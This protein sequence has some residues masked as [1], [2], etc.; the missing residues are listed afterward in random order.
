MEGA[1]TTVS[2]IVLRPI[3]PAEVLILLAVLGAAAV[4]LA[5]ARGLKGAWL[6]LLSLAALLLALANP[7]LVREDRASLSDVV[8]R[9]RS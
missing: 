1:L 4:L 8:M 5:L 7:A 6:R 9:Y 2:D 3:A